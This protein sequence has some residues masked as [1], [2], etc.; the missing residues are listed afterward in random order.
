MK[1]ETLTN[2]PCIV[3]GGGNFN[4]RI[5]DQY[6]KLT[7]ISEYSSMMS[8]SSDH[9]LVDALAECMDCGH[10]QTNPRLSMHEVLGGYESAI[11]L[12]HAD[13]DV[14]RVR[15]FRRTLEKLSSIETLTKLSMP[16][17]LDIGCASGAFL[18]GCKT[19][20]SWSGVGIEPSAWM[21]EFGKSQYGL[22]LR[23][24]Y[25]SA[26][27]FPNERFDLVTLWDVIEH[28]PDP[29]LV[30]QDIGKVLA[31][32]GLLLIN[33]PNS[34]SFVAR[35]LGK[36][37]PFILAV[38]IHY[39]THS[40]LAVL[41]ETHGFRIIEQRPYF[42]ELGLGYIARRALRIIGF[43]SS[44]FSF[45]T[46]LDRIGIRYNMGQTTFVSKRITDLHG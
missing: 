7:S 24:G 23:S 42:Q 43:R 1:P 25:F 26:N 28:I 37:W 44:D 36:R 45:L 22:D 4:P 18:H 40:S 46:K 9:A 31:D 3:C 20:F 27:E 33:V 30:L 12:T 17:V 35:V 6:H 32:N 10:M 8:S 5:S 11:D 19:N 41:L 14:Y 2:F 21:C 13:Q 34:D 16:R 39:F 38:H 15:S 29:N